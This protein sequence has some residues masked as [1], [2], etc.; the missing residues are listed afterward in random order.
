VQIA[1]RYG[2]RPVTDVEREAVRI[3]YSLEARAFGSHRPLPSTLAEM[4]RFWEDYADTELRHEPQN[5]RL[6]DAFMAFLATLL[7]APLR[8]IVPPLL[9]AQVDPR[10]LR[11]CGLREPSRGRAAL[12][13]AMM[14][15]LGRQDPRPDAP[16]GE[17]A[18]PRSALISSVYPGGWEVHT[19]GTHLDDQRGDPADTRPG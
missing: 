14:H 16:A 4:R 8:R 5:Q 3:H 9:L 15:L 19:V 12:S 17:N 1:E 11:A 2:W 7:P 10:I 13:N 18:D 6:T